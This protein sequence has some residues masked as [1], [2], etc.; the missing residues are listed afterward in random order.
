LSTTRIKGKRGDQVKKWMSGKEKFENIEKNLEKTN[1]AGTG[2]GW[3]KVAKH[4][5]E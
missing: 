1:A 3:V 4:N 5:S 2:E